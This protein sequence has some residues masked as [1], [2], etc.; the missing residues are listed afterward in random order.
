[1]MNMIYV[2]HDYNR[3]CGLCSLL[4]CGGMPGSSFVFWT[5]GYANDHN[6][7]ASNMI[8]L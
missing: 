3:V 5:V 4:K 1:M 6:L 2:P 7:E 8:N